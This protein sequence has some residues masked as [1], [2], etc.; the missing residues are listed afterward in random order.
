MKRTIILFSLLCL[1]IQAF[2]QYFVFE[3]SLWSYASIGCHTGPIGYRWVKFQGDT[4]IDGVKYKQELHAFDSL[5]SQ[6]VLKGLYYEDSIGRVYRKWLWGDYEALAFD[7]SVQKGDSLLC[8]FHQFYLYVDSVSISPFGLSSELRKQIFF[9]C[10]IRWIEGLGDLRGPYDLYDCLEPT[11]GREEL[12]CY[13][14]NNELVYRNEKYSSCFPKV[15]SVQEVTPSNLQF[16]VTPR[17][18][19]IHF[20]AQGLDTHQ[21][22]LQILDI[23]GRLVANRT[24]AGEQEWE[25]PMGSHPPG[26][27][28][29]KLNAAGGVLAGKFYVR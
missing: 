16:R 4:T 29:Y 19:L 22:Q 10:G 14:E 5:Q 27:Y 15:T 13:F 17:N 6:W 20:Q 21:A 2:P 12:V 28:I 26:V 25:V 8:S 9:S 23:T 3:S 18:G 11:G 1:I 7:F 24:L